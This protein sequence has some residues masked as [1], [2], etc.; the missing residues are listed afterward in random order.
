MDT[1]QEIYIYIFCLQKTKLRSR[2]TYR[3]KLRGWENVLQ[4]NKNQKKAGVSIPIS[5]KID[6]KIKTVI[7]GKEGYYLIIKGS[8]K[9]RL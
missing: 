5:D 1:I 9:K 8:I 6:L 7:G 3:L 2:D 4:A